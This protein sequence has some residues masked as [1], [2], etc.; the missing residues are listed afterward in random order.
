[1]LPWFITRMDATSW[2]F[3]LAKLFTKPTD[4]LATFGFLQMEVGSPSSIT[5]SDGMTAVRFAS[6][7]WPETKPLCRLVG[8]GHTVWLGLAKATKYGSARWKV[9]L[10]TA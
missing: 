10:V 3:R 2:S 7:T 1:M 5:L 6:S 9:D 8:D 4:R